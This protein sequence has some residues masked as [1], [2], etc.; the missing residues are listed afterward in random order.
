M[1]EIAPL[2]MGVAMFWLIGWGI[3]TGSASRRRLKLAQMHA[4]LQSRVL[5]KVNNSQELAE[6]L[7]SEAGK[8]LLVSAPVERTNPYAGILSSIQAG[9][10]L[11]LAGAVGSA[12]VTAQPVG[13]P[14]GT[15]MFASGHLDHHCRICSWSVVASLNPCCVSG[16][17]PPGL[18][19]KTGTP[20]RA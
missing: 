8:E 6:V 11:S 20:R 7:N 5:D 18:S 9:I 15:P 4:D 12:A 17:F 1:E 13:L 19:G 10:V 16:A 14:V 2:I 3:K